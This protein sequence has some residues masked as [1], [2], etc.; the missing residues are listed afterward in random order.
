[1]GCIGLLF[2]ECY[3]CAHSITFRIKCGSEYLF[4]R[5]KCHLNDI[6]SS[7][8]CESSRMGAYHPTRLWGGRN[9]VRCCPW[10]KHTH[11][12]SWSLLISGGC[13]LVFRSLNIKQIIG[14]KTKRHCLMKC[15]NLLNQEMARVNDFTSKE[16]P[17]SYK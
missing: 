11:I 4:R 14:H 2:G 16:T 17:A 7:C 8:Q 9:S 5:R 3:R 6:I 1:M 10:F 12:I 15:S 13:C